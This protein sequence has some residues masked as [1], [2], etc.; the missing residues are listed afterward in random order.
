MLNASLRFSSSYP[1]YL[2][3]VS[4]I[5]AA[6]FSF[7]TYRRTTPPVKP[8]LRYC[9]IFL[10]WSSLSLALIFIFQL[11]ITRYKTYSKPA[12][13]LV[14]TDKSASMNLAKDNTE[15]FGSVKD[16]L[17]SDG[18]KRLSDR[19]IARLFSFSDSLEH[20][21]TNTSALLDSPNTGIGT[22]LG[23]A[24]MQALEKYGADLPAA[25]LLI[26]DG[27]H[28]KG[29]DPARIARLAHVPIYT[30]GVGSPEASLDLMISSVS[31]NP[32]V[33][34]GSQVPVEIG[35]RAVGVSGKTLQLTLFDQIGKVI[36]NQSMRILDDFTEGTLRFEIPVDSAGRHKYSVSIKPFENELTYNNNKRSFYLNVLA[37]KMRVLVMSGPPDQ[38]LGDLIRRLGNDEQVDVIQR[39]TRGTR[40]Y[41]GDW[42]DDELLSNID[43]VL[44]H[45]FPVGSN[46]KN[47]L[48]VFTRQLSDGNIPIGFI[49]GGNVDIN[50]FKLIEPLL[51]VKALDGRS[52]IIRGYV[53]PIQRHAVI[54]ESDETDIN[55]GWSDLPP[56]LTTANRYQ[57]KAQASVLAEFQDENSDITYPAI[58]VSETGGMKSGVILVYDIWRWGLKSPGEDGIPEPLFQ[59]M[60]RWLAIRKIDKRVKL[61]F[62]KEL[63][64]I[65]EQVGFTVTVL[66]ENYNPMEGVDVSADILLDSKQG[67]RTALLGIGNGR[68]RGGF[69]AWS[70]GEYQVNIKAELNKNVIGQD[71]GKITVEQFSIELLDVR[72]NEELLKFI[73]EASK[74]SYCRISNA[75][76]LLE[77]LSFK[78]VECEDMQVIQTFG[79]VWLLILIISLLIVE[80]TIRIRT[81]ML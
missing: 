15:S 22:D 27:A 75:D 61:V 54:V 19:Y 53:N 38:D 67:G 66:D 37:N 2:I 34:Q 41:E 10:R 4:V 72:L 39:T 5:F 81:G 70:E 68:Y 64:S 74:G 71:K 28:N 21:W 33:Y 30:V 51:G 79:K 29:V 78:P 47:A 24:W 1:I 43:V 62:D 16:L 32:V 9:L 35:Y 69:R 11:T 63:F 57:V 56:V 48:E 80:W 73:S 25:I 60:I 17:E 14:L 40:F 58:V 7:W 50:R 49:D 6:V 46:K 42:P 26:T 3:I 76:S 65:Q 44:L 20:E 12:K 31:V 8:W 13:I 45:H 18:Y 77:S 52:R 36:K 55:R 23:G 59:R